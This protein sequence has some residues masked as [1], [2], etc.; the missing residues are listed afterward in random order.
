MVHA[1]ETTRSQIAPQ[2]GDILEYTSELGDWYPSGKIERIAEDTAT[3]CLEG[4]SYVF[5]FPLSFQTSGGPWV[6]VPVADFRFKEKRKRSF[7]LPSTST[8]HQRGMMIEAYV[9]VWVFNEPDPIYGEYT[10][11]DWNKNI[12]SH[13]TDECKKERAGGE[14]IDFLNC[15]IFETAADFA[16]WKDTYKVVEFMNSDETASVV[17]SYRERLHVLSK[18]EYLKLDLPVDT[19]WNN[20]DIVIV[21]FAYD[22]ETHT[23][24]TYSYAGE[25]APRAFSGTTHKD[26]IVDRRSTAK[27]FE[28]ARHGSNWYQEKGRIWTKN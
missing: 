2:A 5:A 14:Y 22:D 6:D 24:D 27:V 3:V 26:L 17:F 9:N 15:L 13:C 10:T 19:R 11:K 8:L 28:R 25:V 23:V 4:G 7:C 16:A 20:G 18:E 21:K 1:I 12:L